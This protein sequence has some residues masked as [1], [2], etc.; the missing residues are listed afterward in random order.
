MMACSVVVVAD[1]SPQA[2]LQAS[3]SSLL[4]VSWLRLPPLP[5][6]LSPPALALPSVLLFAAGG[7]ECSGSSNQFV[8]GAGKHGAAPVPCGGGCQGPQGPAAVVGVVSQ[9]GLMVWVGV[10]QALV[11]Q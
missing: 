1:V 11:V 3:C 4:G 5:S 8:V 9:S 10:A 2:W 7:S 6:W